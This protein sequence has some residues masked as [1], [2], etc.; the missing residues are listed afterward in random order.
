MRRKPTLP[1]KVRIT[2][3]V[4]YR[5]IISD[6]L[7]KD[8]LGECRFEEKHIIIKQGLSYSESIKVLIHELLHCIEWHGLKRDIS[9]K[10]IYDLENPIFKILLL[11][12]W[13]K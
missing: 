9:H 3:K 11:N 12:K 5:V 4:T 6:E 8:T 10:L 1:S 2:S 13:I 7:D